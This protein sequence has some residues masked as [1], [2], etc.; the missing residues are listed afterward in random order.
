MLASVSR[1]LNEL[2]KFKGLAT[3][4]PAQREKVISRAPTLIRLPIVEA[5][6]P[7]GVT[8]PDARADAAISVLDDVT[9]S[10]TDPVDR[11]A[12]RFGLGFEGARDRRH[13]LEHATD[14]LKQ[15]E[16]ELD[17]S[18]LQTRLTNYLWELLA[19]SLIR[20]DPSSASEN[21]DNPAALDE[22]PM[23]DSEQPKPSDP[24]DELPDEPNE[25]VLV[26]SGSRSVSAM[27][28]GAAGC[29]RDRRVA[30]GRCLTNGLHCNRCRHIVSRCHP[31]REPAIANNCRS[32][33]GACHRG[34]WLRLR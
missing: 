20:S 1:E 32:G 5:A 2:S 22:P 28:L 3:P 10:W 16:V 21:A 12:L 23:A 33:P 27:F 4:K 13:R 6:L 34:A 8:D 29:G 26:G 11:S 19:S 18:S 25:S 14:Q 15:A 7:V 17:Y 9:A 30:S 31:Q 24:Y